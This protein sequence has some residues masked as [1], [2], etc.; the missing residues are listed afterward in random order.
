M[1]KAAFTA[2]P[3]SLEGYVEARGEKGF[4]VSH[5][6]NAHDDGP[7]GYVGRIFVSE[8]DARMMIAA[9]DMYAAVACIVRNALPVPDPRREWSDGYLVS[10]DEMN[11]LRDALS[12]A[13][14]A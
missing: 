3:W 13:R 7:D 11:A 4:I 14:G 2:G 9:P 10:L 5:G 12:K 6:S 1:T 8:P